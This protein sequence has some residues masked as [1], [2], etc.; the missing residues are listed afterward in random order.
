MSIIYIIDADKTTFYSVL[1]INYYHIDHGR[2]HSDCSMIKKSLKIS[3]G[4]SESVY[5][6]TDNTMAEKVQKDKQLSTKHTH[7]TK[8]RVTRIM[9]AIINKTKVLPSCIDDLIRFWL[10]CL[11]LLVSL[12]PKL[13]FI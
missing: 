5:R 2:L 1:L 13:Y 8:D 4:E 12:L 3:K 7:K 11:G 10:S 9:H 6:R